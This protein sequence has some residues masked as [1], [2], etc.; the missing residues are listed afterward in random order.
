MEKARL[1]RKGKLEWMILKHFHCLNFYSVMYSCIIL[2]EGFAEYK[3]L[4]I[5]KKLITDAQLEA[6]VNFCPIYVE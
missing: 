3:T 1:G 6:T 5:C 4:E 2:Q